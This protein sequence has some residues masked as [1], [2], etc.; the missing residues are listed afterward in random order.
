MTVGGS[1]EFRDWLIEGGEGSSNA[2]S[3]GKWR[4][5]TQGFT[6]CATN[7]MDEPDQTTG[8]EGRESLAELYSKLADLPLITFG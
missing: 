3:D 6:R 4:P 2:L 8:L 7:I 1:Y 5:I